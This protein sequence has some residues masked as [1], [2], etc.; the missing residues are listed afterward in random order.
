MEDFIYKCS[1]WA[2]LEKWSLTSWGLHFYTPSRKQV[3]G[4]DSFLNPFTTVLTALYCITSP[5]HWHR[6]LVSILLL[7]L[8]L[9]WK[10]KLKHFLHPLSQS[11]MGDKKTKSIVHFKKT[12]ERE[13]TCGIK[14]LSQDLYI[15]LSLLFTLPMWPP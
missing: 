10:E 14:G 5:L 12:G 9:F 15:Y 13:F 2:Y 11:K 6:I 4:P 1:S 3:A 7:L 8:L